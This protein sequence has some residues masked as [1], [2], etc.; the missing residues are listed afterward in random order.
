MNEP[1]DR[2][3]RLIGIVIAVG[4]LL[5]A[6]AGIVGG[7]VS[8]GE[9]LEEA[10]TPGPGACA[11]QSCKSLGHAC[12]THDDGCGRELRCGECSAGQVCD[13]GVCSEARATSSAPATDDAA[14]APSAL[15]PSAPA[16]IPYGH[17]SPSAVGKTI[18]VGV[19]APVPEVPYSG[20]EP[21]TQ[22]GTTVE[23]VTFDYCPKVHADDVTFRNVIIDCNDHFGIEVSEARNVLVE[24]SRVFNDQDGK[25]IYVENVTNLRVRNN[26]I[27]GGQ[28]WFYFTGE[29]DDIYVENNY[30]HHVV[31]NAEAHSDGFQWHATSN[32]GSFTIRG[33]YM[34]LNNRDIG[35]TDALF[36]TDPT[37]S[38]LFENNYLGRFGYYTIRCQGCSGDLTVRNNVFS[39]RLEKGLRASGP[40]IAAILYEPVGRTRSG[41]FRCNRYENGR[42]VEQRYIDAARPLRHVT[43][44]CPNYPPATR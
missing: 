38:V 18:G 12:G 27:S 1:V 40:P 8:I 21:I 5:V 39:R 37:A 2:I 25:A 10:R 14:P 29:L 16:P 4:A 41:V 36:L 11:P 42:F 31:G 34:T 19:V 28:D 23:N 26:D 44:G 35:V 24:Y 30:L 22:D 20:P 33:N 32:N 9:N 7:G 43:K 13:E 6:A 17:V 3:P 15:P